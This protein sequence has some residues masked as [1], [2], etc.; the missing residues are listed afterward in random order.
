MQEAGEGVTVVVGI[1]GPCLG[2][3]IVIPRSGDS[4][5]ASGD[6]SDTI[7]DQP[8][9]AG[10]GR[11]PDLDAEPIPGMA[12]RR[13]RDAQARAAALAD[14]TRGSIYLYMRYD[15]GGISTPRS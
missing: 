9:T 1:V 13:M 2:H 5:K 8:G 3:A 6:E 14:A 15:P 12:Q 10:P 4:T 7:A 11:W